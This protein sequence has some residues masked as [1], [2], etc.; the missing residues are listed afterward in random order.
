MEQPLEKKLL[1]IVNP[2]SG[3]KTIVRYLPQVIRIFMD[4]GYLV[5]TMVTAG[6]GDA[7]RLA[8]QYARQFD[9]IVCT[10]GDGTMNETLTGLVRGK[11]CV[12]I[13][14][15]PCGSTNDFAVSHGLPTDIP[16]AAEAIA[17]GKTRCYDLG[18]FEDRIFTYVAAFGAFVSLS[19]TTDQN[20]KNLFGH[21]AYLLGGISDLAQI[22]PIPLKVTADGAVYDGEFLFGAVCNTISIAGAI[23][24]PV[25][26]EETADGLLEV[27]LVRVPETLVEL[28]D[29]VVGLLTQDYTSPCMDLIKAKEIVFETEEP[30]T[31]SLDGEAS[32]PYRKVRITPLSDFFY[33]QS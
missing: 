7:T 20:L 17:H 23:E 10:G 5:T 30:M 21:A 25:G 28:N 4:A 12:P 2:V 22:K 27:L 33:L 31:W 6:R 29:I 24:L 19:Y 8:E 11:T 16:E 26:L 9:L 14:Y 3:K 1:L 15:I 32:E 18:C 13:G